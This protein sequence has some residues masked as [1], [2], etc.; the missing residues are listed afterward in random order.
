[1]ADDYRAQVTDNF[2]KGLMVYLTAG[3]TA[4]LHYVRTDGRDLGRVELSLAE[5][6]T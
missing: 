5:C 2:C 1:M 3:A 4:T 6:T